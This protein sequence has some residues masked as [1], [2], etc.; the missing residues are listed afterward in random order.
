M[1][2]LDDL[3]LEGLRS[4]NLIVKVDNQRAASNFGVV[5]GVGTGDALE[6][7]IGLLVGTKHVEGQRGC[8]AIR[9]ISGKE[10]IQEMEF[11]WR[12][13]GK[14]LVAEEVCHN[15]FGSG[16]VDNFQTILFHN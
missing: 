14:G 10:F 2:P 11:I 16:K 1:V 8:I 13:V 4:N 9:S 6:L 7:G 12:L 5:V 3:G 15:I